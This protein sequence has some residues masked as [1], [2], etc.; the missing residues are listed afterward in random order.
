MKNSRLHAKWDLLPADE[1]ER[2]QMAQLRRYLRDVVLPFSPFY[3]GRI[4]QGCHPV[5]AP[6]QGSRALAIHL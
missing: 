4:E 6:L 3:S 2:L 5:A 1:L